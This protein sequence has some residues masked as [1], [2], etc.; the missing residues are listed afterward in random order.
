[1]KR[2]YFLSVFPLF[3]LVALFGYENND[4]ALQPEHTIKNEASASKAVSKG[5]KS[6]KNTALDYNVRIRSNSAEILYVSLVSSFDGVTTIGDQFPLLPNDSVRYFLAASTNYQV[7]VVDETGATF[8]SAPILVPF[9]TYPNGGSYHYNVHQVIR[10]G[11]NIF[12]T[13]N[14][15]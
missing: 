11:A 8:V 5:T 13:G 7:K 14:T 6:Q 9:Y 2:K 12:I 15:L 4:H 10:Q 1:M 3:L